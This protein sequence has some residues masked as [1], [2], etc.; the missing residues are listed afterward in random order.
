MRIERSFVS[1]P[2]GSK[3]AV[4]FVGDG[5]R[6]VFVVGGASGS[7]VVREPL[8][9][10]LARSGA[11]CILMDIAA[12]GQSRHSG[13]LS[14]DTWLQDAEHVFGQY[15]GERAVWVGLSLGAWLMI[16]LHRRHP[17]WFSNMC[18]LAPAFD[19]DRS[20]VIPALQQGRLTTANGVVLWNSLPL[21]ST[22][23]VTSMERHHVVG[24]PTQLEAPLHVI[25]G[26]KDDVAP[27]ALVEQFLSTAT[28]ARCT[29][30]YV[31]E[32]DHGIAKLSPAAVADRFERWLACALL[33]GQGPVSQ[34]FSSP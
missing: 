18:G 13:V 9:A 10:I 11:R 33:C 24:A 32:G 25:F 12:S 16:L 8:V 20:Y 28:G 21:V 15:V 27:P 22:E 3:V 31:A 5:E 14:I 4:H 1:T 2:T 19:W 34:V 29:S 17:G 6:P 30:D 7:G 23:L 26:G